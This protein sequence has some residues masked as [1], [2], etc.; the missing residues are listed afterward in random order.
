MTHLKK[1]ENGLSLIVL[2]EQALSVTFAIMV[3]AGCV[4]ETEKNNGISHYIEHVNFKGT[5][6][7][8]AFDIAVVPEVN[9][10]IDI[11]LLSISTS[12]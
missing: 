12:L 5:D 4:N 3:G 9:S 6:K 8:T 1:Y 10:I 7:L 11:L 2:E